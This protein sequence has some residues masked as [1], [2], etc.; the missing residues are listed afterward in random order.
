LH[1][2]NIQNFFMS[3]MKRGQKIILNNLLDKYVNNY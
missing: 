3:Q 1:E 2:N